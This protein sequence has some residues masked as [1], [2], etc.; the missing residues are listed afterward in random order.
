MQELRLASWGKSGLPQAS[1]L[2]KNQG[3]C[4]DAGQAGKQCAA[5]ASK[6][7]NPQLKGILEGILKKLDEHAANVGKQDRGRPGQKGNPGER[8]NSNGNAAGRNSHCTHGQLL[9]R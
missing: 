5:A 9:N 1:T 4:R 3:R 6:Q 7:A 8:G 2:G